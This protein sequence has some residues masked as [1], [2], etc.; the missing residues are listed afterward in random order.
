VAERDHT[1]KDSP[2]YWFVLL[3]AALD[4]GQY[5]A[6]TR[7][8]RELHRLGIRVTYGSPAVDHPRVRCAGT[9]PRQHGH[10]ISRPSVSA[11]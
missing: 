1:F 4:R 3:D 8:R 11:T 10:G 9:D 6:A 5:E 7:A 2:V